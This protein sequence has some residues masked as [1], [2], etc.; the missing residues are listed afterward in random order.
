MPGEFYIE[1]KAEKVDLTEIRNII[2]QLQTGVT[3]VQDIINQVQNDVIQIQSDIDSIPTD[4]VELL[5][6][7]DF[8]S[9][10][11]TEAEIDS[12]GVTVSLPGVTVGGLPDG[13]TVLRAIAIF[14]FRMIENTDASANALD[15]DTEPATS[16]VIQVRDDTPSDWIDAINFVD[17]QFGLGGET[18]ESGDV[19]IGSIDISGI[20]VGNA[21]YEFQWLLGRANQDSIIFNDIQMGIRVWFSTP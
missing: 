5:T 19:C 14:K 2:S 20:V 17:G 16:Q 3:Q 15:G 7:T 10:P 8:W 6:F 18:R 13:A 12:A 11:I 4:V 9:N 1:G 21:G